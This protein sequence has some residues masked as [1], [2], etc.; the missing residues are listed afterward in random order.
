MV[1]IMAEVTHSFAE[2]YDMEF[3]RLGGDRGHIHLLCSAD[4]KIILGQ[5]VRMFK[6]ITGQ[7]VFLSKPAFKEELWG[8]EFCSYGYYVWQ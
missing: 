7:E 6:S 2:R 1:E 8:G 4:Q 5:M 3:E